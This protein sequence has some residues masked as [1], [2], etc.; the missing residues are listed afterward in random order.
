MQICPIQGHQ[1][2]CASNKVSSELHVVNQAVRTS[3]ESWCPTLILYGVTTQTNSNLHRR[4]DL[5]HQV[6]S[7]S[8]FWKFSIL[9]ISMLNF[10][11]FL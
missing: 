8:L 11:T 1:L 9:R 3:L 10:L 5:S 2:Q 6:R 4:K 7:L